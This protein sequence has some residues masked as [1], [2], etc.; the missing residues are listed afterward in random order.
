MHA[1]HPDSLCS[2]VMTEARLAAPEHEAAGQA[3]K[4]QKCPQADCM[5]YVRDMSKNHATAPECLLQHYLQHPLHGNHVN[6]VHLYSGIL[7]H[8]QI[9]CNNAIC[10]KMDEPR[11]YTD[12]SKSDRE[13]K[14]CSTP[15]ICGI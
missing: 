6:V 10:S 4:G 11:D 3:E 15:I 5:F 9:E 2:P 7:L 1:P 14:H 8:H 12:W 13:E